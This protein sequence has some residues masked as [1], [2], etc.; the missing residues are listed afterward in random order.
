MGPT[1]PDLLS[2]AGRRADLDGGRR[3]AF[4][5]RR[6]AAHVSFAGGQLASLFGEDAKRLFFDNASFEYK[7]MTGVSLADGGRISG[8][9]LGGVLRVKPAAKFHVS[10]LSDKGEGGRH[11]HGEL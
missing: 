4:L 7:E 5:E 1:G 9:Q 11:G 6:G 3:Q 10:I 8:R 2:A